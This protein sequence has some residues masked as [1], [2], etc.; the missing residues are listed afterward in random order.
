MIINFRFQA[1]LRK[2]EKSQSSLQL[3]IMVMLICRGDSLKPF[4]EEM[5]LRTHLFQ[6]TMMI[7]SLNTVLMKDQSSQP[8]QIQ[9]NKDSHQN[10]RFDRKANSLT[11]KTRKRRKVRMKK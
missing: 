6:N 5:N 9:M 10:I 7:Y 1:V 11:K 2:N 3:T 4:K 8:Q